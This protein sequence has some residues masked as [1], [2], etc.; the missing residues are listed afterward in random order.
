M[1]KYVIELGCGETT[2]ARAPGKF[3]R[4]CVARMDGSAPRCTFFDVYLY[5]E[6]DGWLKRCGSCLED[7]VLVADGYSFDFDCGRHEGQADVCAELRSILD[8]KDRHHWNKYGLMKEVT[9]LHQN[10]KR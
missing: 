6:K 3:C 5:E 7:T 9:R 2:C 4:F 1:S 10:S 8:P